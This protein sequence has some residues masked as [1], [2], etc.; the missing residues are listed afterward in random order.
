MKYIVIFL[1]ISTTVF[2]RDFT[3]SA[4]INI[5]EPSDTILAVCALNEKYIME[6]GSTINIRLYI[7]NAMINKTVKWLSMQTVPVEGFTFSHTPEYIYNL[8]TEFGEEVSYFDI[9]TTADDNIAFGHY[10]VDFLVGTDEYM[11][12]AFSDEIMI[13]VRPYSSELSFVYG[14]VIIIIVIAMFT[15]FFWIMKINKKHK[16]LAKKRKYKKRST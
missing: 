16:K 12:G 5:I 1:L 13:K 3:G 6:P 10:R 8:T 11:E 14:S 15:R 9:A 2:A 7:R 4:E